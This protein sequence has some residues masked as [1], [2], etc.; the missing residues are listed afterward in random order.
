MSESLN[1]LSCQCHLIEESTSCYTHTHL[2]TDA[3]T[4]P[5]VHAH[6]ERIEEIMH[7]QGRQTDNK[8][9][10]QKC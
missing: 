2:C 10:K 5:H 1:I 3:H 9:K 6:T 4:P 8:N 7:R